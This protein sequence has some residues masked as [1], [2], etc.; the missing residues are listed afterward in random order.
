MP[1]PAAQLGICVVGTDIREHAAIDAP[2]L[3]WL[4]EGTLLEVSE[5]GPQWCRVAAPTGARGFA[6]IDAL[7]LVDNSRP[8]AFLAADRTL[9]AATVEAP[10]DRRLEARSGGSRASAVARAWN[11]YGGLL[12]VL[13]ERIGIDPAAAVAVLCVESSGQAFG[14]D[15][16]VII[17]FENHIFR[18][19]LGPLRRAEFDRHFEVGG[20]Q[21]WLGHRYRRSPSEPWRAFHGSQALEWDALGV[22]RRLEDEAALR[23]ISMGLPQV[24]G[25]NHSLVGYRSAAHMLAFMA[26]DV[27]FHL[28]ALFDFVRQW[29]AESRT[30][31]ALR[32]GEYDAFA[33]LYNG[34]GQAQY[35]GDLIES[36]VAAYRSLR[37]TA[38][39][40]GS[41]VKTAAAPAARVVRGTAETYEVRPGDTLGVIAGRFG[42][43]VGAIAALNGIANP[44]VIAVGQRLRLPVAET[45]PPPPAVPSA[46]PEDV[47][48]DGAPKAGENYIVQPG[49]TLG[50]I[51]RRVGR[52]V[53][54]LAEANGIR[55]VN[56]I[57]PGQVIAIPPE[58]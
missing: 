45:P 37:A 39:A 26:A 44:N 12:Q 23:S 3:E 42:T 2:P 27:R 50:V 47:T 15:G 17:R 40:S 33:A 6:R 34:P 22:A 21:P 4:D 14:A 30:V 24:M 56:R 29:Q 46:P 31:S 32:R 5:T 41:A 48:A 25:F 18:R 54:I 9:Q 36:H 28:L 52:S 43:T 58:A 55:D 20:E 49:D 11:L 57:F 7:A 51:A 1:D 16:R 10:T 53:P 8:D 13:S 19:Y 35:Y 38:P